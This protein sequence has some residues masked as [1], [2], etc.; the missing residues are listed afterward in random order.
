MSWSRTR[1]VLGGPAVAA[2]LMLVVACGGAEV[3]PAAEEAS[4]EVAAVL[5]GSVPINELPNPYSSVD[6]WAKL[7]D[8][9]EWGS[10]GRR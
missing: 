2:L 1:D 7:P 5:D 8:G 6:G 4:A 3:E 10:D 9:R